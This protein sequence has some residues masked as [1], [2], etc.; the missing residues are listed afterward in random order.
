[1]KEEAE[2][3]SNGMSYNFNKEVSVVADKSKESFDDNWVSQVKTHNK[4]RILHDILPS[5]YVLKAYRNSQVS[6]RAYR[7]DS[8]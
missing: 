6:L 2:S 8:I 5:L 4:A 3:Q 7:N 1:M